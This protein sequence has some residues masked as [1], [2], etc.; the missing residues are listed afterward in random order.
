MSI[1]YFGQFNPFHYSSLPLPSHPHYSTAFFFK[2]SC[3]VLWHTYN[4]LFYK[5][6]TDRPSCYNS[7]FY[8][9]FILC[10]LPPWFIKIFT[11]F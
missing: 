10:V 8:W 5:V 2:Q 3:S 11:F 7:L 9:V 4:S 6:V 1:L